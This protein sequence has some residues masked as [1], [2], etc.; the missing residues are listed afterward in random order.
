MSRLDEEM[1]R[2]LDRTDLDDKTKAQEYSRVLGQYLE[3]KEQYS[4]PVPIP[5]V[6]QKQATISSNINSQ[7]FPQNSRRKAEALLE[8][9][10]ET[11]GIDWNERKE[12]VLDG[13]TLH[14]TNVVDLV[15]DL[16][17]PQ[18]KKEPRGIDP[19]VKA[20]RL[21]NVPES[22]VA[23]RRRLEWST[24]A[25]PPPP[26][27]PTPPHTLKRKQTRKSPRHAKWNIW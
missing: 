5:I 3:V 13:N 23:N 9:I 27:S 19:F 17:R 7:L 18:T 24:T 10:K 15:D 4:R 1:K 2:I 14:S 6:D 26:T 20:L 11:P 8:F 21:A 25:T 22:F 12:L 16:S